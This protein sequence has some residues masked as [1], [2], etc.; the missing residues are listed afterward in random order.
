MSQLYSLLYLRKQ[1]TI[2]RAFSMFSSL[3]VVLSACKAQRKD[4]ITADAKWCTLY[5]SQKSFRAAR[6]N[7]TTNSPISL[8]LRCD[9]QITMDCVGQPAFYCFHAIAFDEAACG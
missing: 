8:W 1:S 2:L 6:G 4:N 9:T 3:V 5:G 7:E